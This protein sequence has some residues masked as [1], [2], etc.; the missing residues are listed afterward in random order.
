MLTRLAESP[1]LKRLHFRA[2]CH[3]SVRAP[4]LF[5]DLGFT[6]LDQ[7]LKPIR[8]QGAGQFMKQHHEADV[9]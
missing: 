9:Q 6:D 2:L 3:V 5:A 1:E 8:N 4:T 7:R